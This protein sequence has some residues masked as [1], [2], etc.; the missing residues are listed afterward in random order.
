MKLVGESS[1]LT[2]VALNPAP[3]D[4]SRDAPYEYKTSCGS[5]FPDSSLE[6]IGLESRDNWH[7]QW[8]AAKAPR[9]R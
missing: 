3:R 4:Y 2:P 5:E 8:R 6:S 7:T 9:L 1:G